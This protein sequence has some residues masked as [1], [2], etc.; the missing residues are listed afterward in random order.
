MISHLFTNYAR[1]LLKNWKFY[2]QFWLCFFPYWCFCAISEQDCSLLKDKTHCLKKPR[3]KVV[4]TCICGGYDSLISHSYVSDDWDYICFTDNEELLGT[5]HHPWMI[6]PLVYAELDHTRNNR[7]HK[8]FP[9][10]ILAEY[11]VSLYL[12]GNINIINSEL[13][14][15]IDRELIKKKS[16]T[17]VINK[18]YERTCIYQ[19]AEECKACHLDSATII[20]HQMQFFR[21]LNYPEF[22]GLTENFMIYRRHHDAQVKEV[23]ADWWRWVSNYS[24]R[25]QLSFNFVIWNRHFKIYLF[26]DRFSRKGNCLEFIMHDKKRA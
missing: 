14:D 19:E 24:K 15:Y 23:M 17:L 5:E 22:N 18:H 7:W 26:E 8:I 12:D 4:Y 3:K 9:D 13:F 1:G 21:Q 2:L 25:D 6:R 11:K 10:K 16:K 20:D